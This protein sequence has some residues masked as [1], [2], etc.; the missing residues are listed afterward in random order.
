MRSDGGLRQPRQSRAPA[1]STFQ[2]GAVQQVDIPV[3]MNIR[4]VSAG[5]EL[6]YYHTPKPEKVDGK[7][8]TKAKAP[9]INLSRIWEQAAA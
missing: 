7:P 3:L 2:Q 6:R 1:P 5:Q 4:Q 8:K 9:K